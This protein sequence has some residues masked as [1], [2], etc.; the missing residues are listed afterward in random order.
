M[1]R[2]SRLTGGLFGVLLFLLPT[3]SVAN[4][5]T[6]DDL[7]AYLG[8]NVEER[9]PTMIYSENTSQ[10]E[11]KQSNNKSSELESDIGKLQSNFIEGMKNEVSASELVDTLQDIKTTIGN[12]EDSRRIASVVSNTDVSA[13]I[14]NSEQY[15]REKEQKGLLG[16]R[17]YDIGTIGDLSISPTGRNLTLITPFGY[18]LNKDKTYEKKNTTIDLAVESGN[19]IHSQLNGKIAIIENDS[20]DGAST[21]TIYHGEKLYTV[22]SHIKTDDIYVGKPVS[23]GDIIGK[24]VSTTEYEKDKSNHI[25]YQII[26]DDKYINPILI[27][28]N[29]G[30]GMYEDWLIRSADLYSVEENE[31]YFYKESMSRVNINKDDNGKNTIDGAAKVVGDYRLPDPGVVY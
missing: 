28:G 31:E 18:K 10:S 5:A 21:V 15:E 14:E 1:L 2:Q 22:Y 9:E 16:S 24:S 25:G 11:S 26:L 19:D 23:Q 13:L 30:K 6:V 7:R 3:I 20:I 29:R 4:A 27:F 12:L 8:Y 17:T